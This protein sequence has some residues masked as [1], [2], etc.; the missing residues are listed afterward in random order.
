MSRDKLYQMRRQAYKKHKEQKYMEGWQFKIVVPESN[1]D[2]DLF[3]KDISYGA[4]EIN[5]SEKTIGGAV[6]TSPSSA[7]PVIFG[8]TIRDNERGDFATWFD[9]QASKIFN[10]NGT[11]NLSSKYKFTIEIHTVLKSGETELRESWVVFPTLRGDRTES[12][13]ELGTYVTYP[14]SFPQTNSLGG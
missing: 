4:V 8:V 6:M 11:R 14:I 12:V 5:T 2:F 1:I 9:A 13:D 3:A 7:A 10:P